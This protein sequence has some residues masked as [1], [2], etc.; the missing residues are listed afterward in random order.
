[1]Q[2]SRKDDKRLVNA[3]LASFEDQDSQVRCAVAEGLGKHS[4]M[5][6]GPVIEALHAHL[7]DPASPVRCSVVQ[8]LYRCSENGVGEVIECLGRRRCIRQV[9]LDVI[10]SGVV[11]PD[12]RLASAVRLCLFDRRGVTRAKALSAF[13]RL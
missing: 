3:L 9:A 12:E 10:G 4:E 6:A 8:A 2:I 5:A 7:K 13:T 1:M 11:R